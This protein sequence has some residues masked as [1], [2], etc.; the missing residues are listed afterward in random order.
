M[1]RVGVVL[2]GFGAILVLVYAVLALRAQPVAA[3][4]FF[5]QLPEQAVIAHQGGEGLWPSNTLFAFERA[6]ALGVDVLEMDLHQS[7]DG[8]LVLIHDETV[9][10]T[11]DGEGLVREM[12]LAEIKA[13]DAGAYWSDDEGVTFPY[14]GQ[15][16]KIPTLEEIFEAFPAM[17][18]VIEIKQREPSIVTPFCNLIHRYGREEDVLVASFHTQTM[19]EF[20]E[21][22]PGVATSGT[23][24]EIRPFFILDRL[25]LDAVYEPQAEA[26]Q[27]PEYSG[28]LHVVTRSFVEGAHEHN[29]DVH[30]W[31]VNDPED[32]Q[33]LL[34]LGVDG[35]ITD[36]P[37]LMLELL[38]R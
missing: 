27:V 36:R 14:R 2:L 26:F 30:V 21:T 15:G 9:D 10:R 1:K 18:M 13:L 37:D 34:A 17:P 31:T 12:S 8:A 38:G 29:V 3:H 24:E 32:M 7:A 19:A 11:T 6:T 25:L 23:E 4:P 33:R 20:R 16:L 5:E 35:I 22:C 28:S